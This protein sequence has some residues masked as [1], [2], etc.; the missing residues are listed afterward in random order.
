VTAKLIRFPIERRQ[1]QI[2]VEAIEQAGAEA[3]NDDGFFG[4][5]IR[6]TE[7]VYFDQNGFTWGY[8]SDGTFTLTPS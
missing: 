5:R 8:V 1:A 4:I 2:A 7:P 3:V 6:P